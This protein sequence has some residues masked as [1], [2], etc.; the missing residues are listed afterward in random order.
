MKSLSL[1]AQAVKDAPTRAE[2]LRALADQVVPHM[3]EPD[4]GACD[5]MN[6]DIEL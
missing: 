5:Q 6:C 1:A 2:A 4:W 3:E